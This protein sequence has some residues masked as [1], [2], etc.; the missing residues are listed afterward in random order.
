M[1]NI[2]QVSF[3]FVNIFNELRQTTFIIKDMLSINAFVT[4]HNT[5]TRVQERQFTQTKRQNINIKNDLTDRLGNWPETDTS[6]GY[7]GIAHYF[8]WILRIAMTVF[9]FMNFTGKVNGQFE[10]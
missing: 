5:Y 7:I 4:Q 2:I 1:K 9:L 6:S 3:A 8:S 10:F